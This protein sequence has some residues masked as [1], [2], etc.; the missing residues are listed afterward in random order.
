[1]KRTTVESRL[2]GIDLV[3]GKRIFIG[4]DSGDGEVAANAMLTPCSVGQWLFPLNIE[5]RRSGQS[6]PSV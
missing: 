6:V 2:E 4:E 5:R 3:D 1:L